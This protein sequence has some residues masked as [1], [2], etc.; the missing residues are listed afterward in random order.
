MSQN[1]TILL[2]NSVLNHI[3]KASQD[4]DLCHLKMKMKGTVAALLVMG[5]Y[6]LTYCVVRQHFYVSELLTWPESQQYCRQRYDDLSTVTTMEEKFSLP[7]TVPPPCPNNT[8]YYEECRMWKWI[9][10][11]IDSNNL[12]QWSGGNNEPYF[13]PAI[14]TTKY[15]TGKCGIVWNALAVCIPVPC[16]WN[17]SFYCMKQ[18]DVILVEET[19]T[20]EEAFIYCRSKY[21]DLVHLTSEFWMKEAVKVGWAAQT[22]YV[23]TGLRFLNGQWFWTTHN[24]LKYWAWSTESEPRCPARNLRC[25][26]LAQKKGIWEMRDC[27][28]KLNFLCFCK[29]QQEPQQP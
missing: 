20:W 27:E 16:T 7:L 3:L 19:M 24:A 17:L 9:G 4:R 13:S 25:G 22:P 11:Y 5:L 26:A 2:V 23:W 29:S 21:I 6:G 28:E 1:R 14:Q 18:F 15:A 10:L 12:T 8:D